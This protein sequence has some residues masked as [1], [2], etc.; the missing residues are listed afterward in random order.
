MMDW[1]DRHCRYFHRLLSER[2]LLYSEM[3]VADAAIHGDREKLLGQPKLTGPTAL[4]LGGN[5]PTKLAE[6]TKIGEQFGY[7]EINLNVGCPSDRVQSGVFGACLMKEPDLVARCVEQ[8]NIA[9]KLPVTVKC[10]IGVDDQDPNIALAELSEKVWQVGCDAL[11]VHARKAWLDGLSPKENRTVPPLNYDLV[12]KLKM[13]NQ[14]QFIGLNGGLE[15][16]NQAMSALNCSDKGDISLDGLMFGRVAYQTPKLL[17]E[18]DS[19]FYGLERS[20][21]YQDIIDEMSDYCDAHISAGGKLH[22]VTRH[23]MGL[24]RGFPGG[25]KFRQI[26]SQDAVKIDASS[27]V[28]REA[29]AHV[30]SARQAA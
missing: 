22:H 28:L 14:N 2:A 3:V 1:T 10:R 21:T 6:A 24:F 15:N 5:D 26:L 19:M 25:R 4:Q 8:M 29:F 11:W 9:T 12:R 16:M 17:L 27:A 7:D 23:M 13:K 20:V 30:D 18:V